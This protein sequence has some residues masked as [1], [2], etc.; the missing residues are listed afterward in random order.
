MRHRTYWAGIAG[1]LLAVSALAENSPASRA[2]SVDGEQVTL[3][4]YAKAYIGEGNV[5]V[6]VAPYKKKNGDAGAILVFHGIESDWDGRAVNH[7]VKEE[8]W[9]NL[10]YVATYQGKPWNTLTVRQRDNQTEYTLYPPGTQDEISLAPSDGAAQL[11][12]P[13]ALYE[14]YRQQKDQ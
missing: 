8:G 7:A 3:A 5:R 9:K 10:T 14:I 2:V 1:L 4:H 12:T 11:T 13:A 6:D